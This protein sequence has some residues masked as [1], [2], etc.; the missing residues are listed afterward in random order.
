MWLL[1]VCV[2]TIMLGAS[3]SHDSAISICHIIAK[4]EVPDISA[5]YVV[6]ITLGEVVLML[7]VEAS[8][9]LQD[10]NACKCS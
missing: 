5:I 1:L 4:K 7:S 10:P 2:Y 3:V 8:R 9:I 6:R